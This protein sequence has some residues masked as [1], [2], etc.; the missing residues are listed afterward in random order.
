MGKKKSKAAAVVLNFFAPG[1]GH[2]YL[3]AI[4]RG[5]AWAI[6]PAIGYVVVELAAKEM[7]TG[8]VVAVV[9]GMIAAWIGSMIDAGVLRE[10]KHRD[11]S[12]ALVIFLSIALF[13]VGRSETFTVRALFLEA[14][15]VPSG[16][17]IPAILVG[18]HL[19]VDKLVYGKRAAARGEVMVFK[20][21]EHPEQDFVKRVVAVGGDRVE[22][23]SQR[24]VINGWEVPRCKVGKWSYDEAF[25][26][27]KHTGE[28]YVE[29][30]G[31]TPYLIFLDDNSLQTD[32]Q[33]PF[34]VEPGHYFVMGDN[35]NNAHDSR[36]WF[37]GQ[38]GTVGPEH[39]KGRARLIWLS[40]STGASRFGIDLGMPA[41]APTPDVATGIANCLAK[42]PPQTIPP[43]PPH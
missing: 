36:M 25:D 16:S 34:T 21:P 12:K 4:G 37:G 6:A 30:L 19:F 26:A 10:E 11:V 24:L 14:F 23:R 29:F 5:L 39:V 2:V 31:T 22:V 9:G 15:K 41:V 38:G 27:T 3:G 35:R 32:Y 17:M 28:L 13:L 42:V 20:Y 8:A 40:S 1:A 43:P 18:D 33:G 7:S